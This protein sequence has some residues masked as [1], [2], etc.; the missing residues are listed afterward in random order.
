MR[1]NSHNLAN[2][3]NRYLNSTNEDTKNA[4]HEF[5]NHIASSIKT[6]TFEDLLTLDNLSQ[7]AFY[8]EILTGVRQD[9]FYIPKMINFLSDFMALHS[10]NKKYDS[11]NLYTK[12]LNYLK[13]IIQLSETLSDMCKKLNNVKSDSIGDADNNQLLMIEKDLW[14]MV[15][16]SNYMAYL[17]MNNPIEYFEWRDRSN[18]K[19][20]A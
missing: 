7:S 6:I 5:S 8:G 16:V 11:L 1:I 20:A 12:E 4:E 13:S 17:L 18:M 15:N 10:E 14:S 3:I 9:K 2:A 19:T